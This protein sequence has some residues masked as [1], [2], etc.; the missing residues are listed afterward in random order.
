[1]PNHTAQKHVAKAEPQARASGRAPFVIGGENIAAGSRQIV[2]LPFSLL[3]NHTPITLPVEVIHGRRDG[4]CVFVSAALHGDELNGIEII[5]RLLTLPNLEKLRGTLIAIPMVNA[6]G[7][8][9]HSRYLP[10]GRD[11]NRSFPGSARG[12]L[13]AQL[14]DLFVREIVDQATHGIDLHTGA[15]NRPNLPQVRAHLADPEV[16]RLAKAFGAPVMINSPPRP[17]SLRETALARKIP[18]LLYE[19]GEAL[20]FDETAIRGG[21]DGILRVLNSLKMLPRRGV[22]SSRLK[23][24]ESHGSYWVRAP[25]SGVLNSYYGLGA[26]IA[27]ETVLASVADPFGQLREEVRARDG[28]IIIGQTLLGSV[29]QGDATFHVARVRNAEAAAETVEAFNEYLADPVDD[30][31]LE[32]NPYR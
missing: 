12:S 20:R 5:R 29:N 28:G 13:A 31:F 6:F 19:A 17:G 7:L 25:I 24:V 4:P 8:I 30:P 16:K 1:M 3:V 32:D 9:G 23:P 26:H 18:I 27:A 21:L 15:V 22:R 10:D 14:A 2:D 11:L